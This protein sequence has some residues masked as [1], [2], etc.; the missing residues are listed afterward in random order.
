MTQ[1][2]KPAHRK[3]DEDAGCQ[4]ADLAIED[5]VREY[6]LRPEGTKAP[7]NEAG[8]TSAYLSLFSQCK[9][10]LQYRGR[11]YTSSRLVSLFISSTTTG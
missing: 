4:K 10:P 6:S 8:Y 1:Q 3:P 5:D 2:V 9:K 7:Q 11:P